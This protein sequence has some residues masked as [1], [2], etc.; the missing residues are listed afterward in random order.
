M[1]NTHL[2]KQEVLRE[3]VAA[4]SVRSVVLVG[5]KG[6]FCLKIRYAQSERLLSNSRRD[7][8]RMFATMPGAMNFLERMGI[9]RFEVDATHF[10]RGR[11][12]AA[13]PY[14]SEA[15]RAGFAAL[16]QTA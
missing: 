4:G 6:G 14:Q 15:L 7:E 9:Q 2:V 1:S 5:Q 16:R 8:V 3:L 11:L 10:E 12:R 13:R